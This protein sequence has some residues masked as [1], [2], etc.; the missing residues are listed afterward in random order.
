[1]TVNGAKKPQ[2]P[3]QN[4]TIRFTFAPTAS[5]V[6]RHTFAVNSVSYS[7]RT[8]PIPVRRKFLHLYVYEPTYFCIVEKLRNRLS[9]T[10]RR[11]RHTV[12]GF[13][14]NLGS[15]FTLEPVSHFILKIL[16]I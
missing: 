1:M 6:P 13:L 10:V 14:R 9:A 16:P 4:C 12:H 3:A 8:D 11:S 5:F 7:C 15:K 2:I